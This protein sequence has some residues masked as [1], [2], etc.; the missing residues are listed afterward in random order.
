MNEKKYLT[1]KFKIRC[2]GPCLDSVT[3]C[4]P[5]YCLT[6]DDWKVNCQ[7]MAHTSFFPVCTA[8]STTDYGS[9]LSFQTIFYL[10][11]FNLCR[12]FYINVHYVLTGQDATFCNILQSLYR[13]MGSEPNKAL[14]THVT[15]LFPPSSSQ[16]RTTPFTVFKPFL[17]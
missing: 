1:L 5:E 3:P 9:I 7:N 14:V 11:E 12:Y 13:C 4:V 15:T 10:D 8:V 6:V 2:I 16:T 17:F